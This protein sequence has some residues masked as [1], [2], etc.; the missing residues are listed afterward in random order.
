MKVA[1]SLSEAAPARPSVVSIGNFDG[2]HLGHRA[3]LEA[4][5]ARAK[6]AGM[7]PVAMTF[8]P[9]PVRFLAP[10][11]SPKLISTLDQKIRL[12][13]EAEIDLLFVAPF[14]RAFSRLSPDQFIRQYLIEGLGARTVCVGS[15]FNFGYR[16]EGRVET[17]RRWKELEV[18][19]IPP[20]RVRDTT[21]SSTRIRELIAAGRVALAGRMLGRWFAI[22]GT[23]V[24]GAGRGRKQTVPTLNL[25]TDNELL[26]GIGVYITRISLDGGRFLDS[27]TNIGVRPTFGESELTIETF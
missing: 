22:E 3:I 24:P 25:R 10:D 21:V 20:V 11:R 23:I 17:L 16:Q 12:I 4:V 27:I 13:E 19:E 9:H 1:S 2:L 26:P 18:I 7:L 6:D 8:S 14:D 5:I 15:N